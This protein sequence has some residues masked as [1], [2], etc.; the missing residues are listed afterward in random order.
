MVPYFSNTQQD[1]SPYYVS[2]YR[3]SGVFFGFGSRFPCSGFQG[4]ISGHWKHYSGHGLPENRCGGQL[5]NGGVAR[6][7]HHCPVFWISLPRVHADGQSYLSR[8]VLW[9]LNYYN[10][11]VHSSYT[12]PNP[13]SSM[14]CLQWVCDKVWELVFRKE[15]SVTQEE[16]AAPPGLW[17]SSSPGEFKH[18]QEGFWLELVEDM[19]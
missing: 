16:E 19:K 14:F 10:F 3:K 9:D 12:R 8:Q 13:L 1:P 7:H 6:L 5:R 17:I 4:S 11:T 2:V 15:R 18:V